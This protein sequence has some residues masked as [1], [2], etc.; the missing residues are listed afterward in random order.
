[1][2]RMHSMPDKIADLQAQVQSLTS[3]NRRLVEALKKCHH[4][5]YDQK[6]WAMIVQICAIA[7][8][9]NSGAGEKGGNDDNRGS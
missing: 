5:A 1:M 4:E 2:S 7:L 6:Q 8:A 9:E 3:S